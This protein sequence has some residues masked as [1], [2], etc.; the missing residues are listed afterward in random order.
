M[1]NTFVVAAGTLYVGQSL[2]NPSSN[3]PLTLCSS[4]WQISD[5]RNYV[6]PEPSADVDPWWTTAHV[7]EVRSGN[8][9]ASSTPPLTSH[10]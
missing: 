9:G 6:L 8:T 10:K 1:S 2:G 4:F 3:F 5:S 7:K